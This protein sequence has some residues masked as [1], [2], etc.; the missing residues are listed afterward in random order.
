MTAP[1]KRVQLAGTI[2]VDQPP[3]RAFALFTPSGERLWAAGWDPV[4]PSPSADETNPG[5]VFT[6]RHSDRDSV[7]TVVRSRAGRLIEYSVTTPG[8]R[9][10][11]VTVTCSG[12]AGGTE[13][14]VSY[15]LTSLTP[16]ANDRLDQFAADY[17][18]FLRQWQHAISAAVSP[19][20]P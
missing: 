7:W 20:P 8:E 9:A 6:V 2:T 5:T 11:L 12:S 14:N 10:G 15:D 19:L 3:A 18:H 1:C 16:A 17:A 13:V 4:F